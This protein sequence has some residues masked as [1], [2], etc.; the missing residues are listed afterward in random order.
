MPSPLV[1][2]TVRVDG[3]RTLGNREMSTTTLRYRVRRRR[4]SARM[5][6]TLRAYTGA[7]RDG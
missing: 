7:R 1:T 3:D 6:D 4:M 5:F 2:I